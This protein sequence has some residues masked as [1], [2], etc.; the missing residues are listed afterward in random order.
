MLVTVEVSALDNQKAVDVVSSCLTM[1]MSVW[2]RQTI[3]EVSM[4]GSPLRPYGLAFFLE[5]SGLKPACPSPLNAFSRPTFSY[6]GAV[7]TATLKQ[8]IFLKPL[9]AYF[10]QLDSSRV[11]CQP[12]DF[13]CLSINLEFKFLLLASFL[14]VWL[15]G[16]KRPSLYNWESHIVG[17]I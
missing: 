10:Q 9:P 8:V 4:W 17:W 11:S 3:H 1:F 2:A 13:P 16:D 7:G 12:A 15:L 6:G 5:L 14:S